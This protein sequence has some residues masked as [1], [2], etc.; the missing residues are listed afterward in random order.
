MVIEMP[1]DWQTILDP[2]AQP[3]SLHF[4]L[5]LNT[6]S[7][8]SELPGFPNKATYS[9]LASD[10]LAQAEASAEMPASPI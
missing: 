10:P 9:S 5:S 7:T 8:G 4:F 6:L 3:T 2:L 1:S